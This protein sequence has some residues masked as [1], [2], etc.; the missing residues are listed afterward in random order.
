[1]ING[2]R[3]LALIPAR[4]GS[5]RLPR[6]N[7]LP[8][9]GKPLIEWTINAAKNSKYIDEIIVS[10]D[11]KEIASHA[12][13]LGVPVPELRPEHLSSDNATTQ[14][15]ISYTLEKFGLN[16][17]CVVVL[18]PTS[19]FRNAKHIDEALD[20]YIE[21]EAFAVIS[22]SPCEHSPLWANTLPPSDSMEN[23]IKLESMQPGQNLAQYHRLNGAIYIYDVKKIKSR[24]EFQYSE[25]TYAYKM[26]IASS[27]DIDTHL[28]FDYA[29]FLMQKSEYNN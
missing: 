20:L 26:N 27:V 6:K 3:V 9:N 21:R 19:P 11:D 17:D 23:F 28:D 25:D 10:T 18:Q 7:I 5:K 16:V 2:K 4:G 1:M 12:S 24:G 8:L 14:D 22:V 29:E 13:K 15:V